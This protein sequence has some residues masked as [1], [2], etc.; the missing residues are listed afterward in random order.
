MSD[1]TELGAARLAGRRSAM[2][3]RFSDEGLALIRA[4]QGVVDAARKLSGYVVAGGGH[5][6]AMQDLMSEVKIYN[7]A[8]VA[9][10]PLRDGCAAPGIWG[11]W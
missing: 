10:H 7:Q 6:Y 9:P 1:T 3:T 4:G 8:E 2:N 5:G 11:C